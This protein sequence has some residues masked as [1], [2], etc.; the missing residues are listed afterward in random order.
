MTSRTL[1]K[2]QRA[3]AFSDDI[4]FDLE[5]L[6]NVHEE[7]GI[8]YRAERD[9]KRA[10]DEEQ[11]EYADAFSGY[12]IALTDLPALC[13]ERIMGMLDSP[14][15]LY[16]VAFSSKLLMN[17]VTPDM[18][19]RSA[20]FNNM[21]RKD[22]GYRKT[23]AEIMQ[24]VSSRSIHL[25]SPHRLLRLLNARTCERGEKCF[26][27]NLNTGKSMTL[28]GTHHRTCGMALCDNCI[29]F[30]STKISYNHFANDLGGGDDDKPSRVAFAS[31]RTLTNPHQDDNG[32]WHGPLVGVL[33]LQQ[34]QNSYSEQDEKVEALSGFVQKALTENSNHCPSHYEEKAVAYTEIYEAAEKEADDYQEK[35]EKEQMQKY[36]ESRQ[37][38]ITKRLTKLRGVHAQMVDIMK[39]CPM[40]DLAMECSWN[41]E[42]ERN[43]LKFE[44]AFVQST[45]SDLLSAPS[46]ASKSAVS[47]RTETIKQKF[48]ILQEK[49]FFSHA[50]IANS[51]NR[52]R[53]A[54]YEY[55][56]NNLTPDKLLKSSRADATFFQLV[57][58][59]KPTRALVRALNGVE[60][61]LE[62]IFSLSVARP[63][64][65]E[66]DAIAEARVARYR[67]LATVVW[68]K[69]K[70]DFRSGPYPYMM[71]M[72]NLKECYTACIEEFRIMKK[73][74]KDYVASAD[75]R[76]FLR[77]EAEG[78]GIISRQEALNLVFAPK[79]Y[80]EWV[81]GNSRIPYD[82]VR[83][84]R[85]GNLRSM[86]E[87]YFRS[88][89]RYQIRRE[90]AL[91]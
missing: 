49:D 78:A 36:D 50:S 48:N 26:G 8:A 3:G 24:H 79:I 71:D 67:K 29:K 34:I 39:E 23:I 54:M 81:A 45:M 82:D 73:N 58:E 42:S 30:N 64:D 53:K 91:A 19:I 72:Q 27:K 83:N 77:R 65:N 25:P 62:D 44:C 33:E 18:V 51:S 70:A 52:F 66:Q 40:K 6:L 75:S 56:V 41:E 2:R 68:Q 15:D 59:N 61:A 90:D 12:E 10:K 16:N 86:H 32:E 5:E 11:A 88:P 47:T 55:C 57:E 1:R 4:D 31:W 89:N 76:A 17:I 37:E 43:L 80:R 74:A 69:K 84:R 46:N 38:R 22:V 35:K 21:K 60:K 13:I 28:S 14:S 85:F 7:T 87:Q 20:V 9:A 63:N